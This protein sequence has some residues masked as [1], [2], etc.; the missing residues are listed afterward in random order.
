MPGADEEY[1]G[2]DDP[3]RPENVVDSRYPQYNACQAALRGFTPVGDGNGFVGGHAGLGN[4]SLQGSVHPRRRNRA[5]QPPA[6]SESRPKKKQH[7]WTS[8]DN[9]HL[10]K[11]LTPEW[12]LEN[13]QEQYFTNIN[14]TTLKTQLYRLGQGR[15][16]A[17]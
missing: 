3:S 1:D 15:T 14:I 17:P 4:S 6:A 2:F 16:A 10:S 8:Q 13:V 9:A 12:T 5:S 11:A 7:K